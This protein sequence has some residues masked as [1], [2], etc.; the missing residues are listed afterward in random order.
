MSHVESKCNYKIENLKVTEQN[1]EA[2]LNSL[3]T[4]SN[5]TNLV[6][7]STKAKQIASKQIAS[8]LYVFIIASRQIA[9]VHYCIQ[10]NCM[11]S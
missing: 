8:K 2:E 5:E 10:T 4:W 9:R 7:N 6:F 1:L 11:C 3:L